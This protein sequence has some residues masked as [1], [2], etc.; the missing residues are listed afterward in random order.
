M[1]QRLRSSDYRLTAQRRAVAEV[2]N[3]VNVHLTADEIHERAVVAVPEISRATVYNTLHELAARGEIRELNLGG[4]S[5]RYDPNVSPHHHLV[6]D[7]CAA[8]FDVQHNIAATELPAA[9]RHGGS[10]SRSEIV[11]Y[12]TCAACSPAS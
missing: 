3:G 6:C 1:L 12:G 10:V 8:V 5:K 2:L 4:R 7:S 9:E 11:H